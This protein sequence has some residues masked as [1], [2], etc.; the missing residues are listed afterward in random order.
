MAVKPLDF[1]VVI[2][3]T[4]EVSRIINEEQSRNFVVLQ[5]QTASV[6]QEVEN[7]L[8]QVSSREQAQKVEMREDQ[9]GRRRREYEERKRKKGTY[10]IEGK[11]EKGE[12]GNII[13]VKI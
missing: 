7:R 4:T 11:K 9:G 3:K 2:P 13:D 1:Q 6:K 5:Q 10:G 8:R 12:P